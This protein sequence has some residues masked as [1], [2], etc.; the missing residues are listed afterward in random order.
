[1]LGSFSRDQG[2]FAT[3]HVLSLKEPTLSCNQVPRCWAPGIAQTL[4]VRFFS[5][6]TSAGFRSTGGW[7][8]CPIH[9][10]VFCGNGWETMP[11]FSCRIN[12]IVQG[13]SAA[14]PWVSSPPSA[15]SRR[16]RMNM[17][18][19]VHDKAISCQLSRKS[20]QLANL[21]SRR[22]P[23]LTCRLCPHPHQLCAFAK[24]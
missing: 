13:G 10:R 24:R 4:S 15:L 12:R 17:K 11:L 22:E 20:S 23:Q 3:T 5:Y 6:S 9:S 19:P 18:N 16:A 21:L 7:R 1:M 2:R 14:K 8:G